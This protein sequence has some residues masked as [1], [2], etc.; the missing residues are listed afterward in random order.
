MYTQA[1]IVLR[2]PPVSYSF[3]YFYDV[4][5]SHPPSLSDLPSNRKEEESTF[6]W[7][8][9]ENLFFPFW[10]LV[11]SRL[12]GEHLFGENDLTFDVYE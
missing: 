1:S 12:W 6:S 2:F 4:T 3:E 11:S 8:V 10:V 5:T 7:L 9:P